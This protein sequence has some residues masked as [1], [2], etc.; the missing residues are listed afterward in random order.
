MIG[1]IVKLYTSHLSKKVHGIKIQKFKRN[2]GL[3][4]I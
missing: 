1:W 4:D 2:D 3:F